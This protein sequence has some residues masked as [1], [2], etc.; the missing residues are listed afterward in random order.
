MNEATA[1]S[2]SMGPIFFPLT[3]SLSL[4]G[5]GNVAATPVPNTPSPLK[6]E[7]QKNIWGGGDLKKGRMA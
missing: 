1:H 7:G 3:L 2:I 6:G 4:Q 5:R